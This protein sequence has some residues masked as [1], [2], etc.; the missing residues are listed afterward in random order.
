MSSK[1]ADDHQMAFREDTQIDQAS[2]LGAADQIHFHLELVKNGLKEIATVGRFTNGTRCRRDDL[3]DL[4]TGGEVSELTERFKTPLHRFRREF[5]GLRITLPQTGSGLFGLD[6][7]KRA[8]FRING[9]HQKMEGVGPEID[10]RDPTQVTV[11]ALRQAVG[12]FRWLG[13]GLG[14]QHQRQSSNESHSATDGRDHKAMTR[15]L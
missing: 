6:D 8:Q 5:T 1:S 10:G 14:I 3:F 4:M 13:W 15:V 12:L 7:L 11:R 9:C 2:L